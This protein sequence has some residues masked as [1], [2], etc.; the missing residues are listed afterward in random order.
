MHA[1]FLWFYHLLL[2]VYSENNIPIKVRLKT[3][4]HVINITVGSCELVLTAAACDDCLLLEFL[5]YC[6]TWSDVTVIWPMI[7]EHALKRDW[8]SCSD[9][10]LTVMFRLM[11][12]SRVLTHDW[13]SCSDSW[14][15]I[16]FWL[17]IDNRVLI[18]DWQ[19]CSDL[20]LTIMFWLVIDNHLLTHWWSCL[21]VLLWYNILVWCTYICM[22][23]CLK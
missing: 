18:R 2:H 11:I 20:L 22:T 23:I 16:M 9:P 1:S 14:L 13:Q 4:W 3:Y 12:D 15:T 8:Q 7:D 21:I 19:S 17:M 10:W 5:P 6:F